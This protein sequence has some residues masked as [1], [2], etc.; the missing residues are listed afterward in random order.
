MKGWSTG[1]TGR[2][3]TE[4]RDAQRGPET[5]CPLSIGV[6]VYIYICVCV[7]LPPQPKEHFV[8]ESYR[9]ILGACSPPVPS[10]PLA[11]L[12]PLLLPGH[13]GF[14]IPEIS[15]VDLCYGTATNP[16]MG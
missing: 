16:P 2:K 12:V 11:E 8:V 14:H 1:I 7:R 13:K 5:G 6:G 9:S 10:G 15:W 3:E 4:Q